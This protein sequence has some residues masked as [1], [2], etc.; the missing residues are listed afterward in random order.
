LVNSIWR[1]VSGPVTAF[2]PP[3]W[4]SFLLDLGLAAVGAV[5]TVRS[6]TSL[7]VLV[8][9]VALTAIVTGAAELVTAA[10]QDAPRL[11]AIAGVA[12]LVVGAGVATW[13]G[14][15]LDVLTVWVGLGLILG[16]VARVLGGI[17][18]TADQRI[19]AVVSG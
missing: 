11:A 12:W 15:T 10:D 17:R 14:L 2:R 8:A 18:G 3:L 19:T 16:G 4:L 7:S 5:L 13:P 1:W 6:F 9:L